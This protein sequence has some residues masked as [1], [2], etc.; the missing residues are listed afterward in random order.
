MATLKI[1]SYERTFWVPEVREVIE[2]RSFRIPEH[3]V[4]GDELVNLAFP[5]P[6][7]SRLPRGF[8][9]T[10]FTKSDLEGKVLYVKTERTPFVASE[11]E[12]WVV[13]SDR[14]YLMSDSGKTIDRI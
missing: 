12:T 4:E 14:C 7:E 9:M 10:S 2:E 5:D 3:V 8:T 6:K 11:W 13:P 1:C